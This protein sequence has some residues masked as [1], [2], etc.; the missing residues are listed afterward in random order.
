MHFPNRFNSSDSFYTSYAPPHYYLRVVLSLSVGF[1]KHISLSVYASYCFICISSFLFLW[2]GFVC[3][4]RKTGRV[5]IVIQKPIKVV[6][7]NSDENWVKT[8]DDE[9]E[10]REKKPPENRSKFWFSLYP[11]T[12][13]SECTV[14]TAKAVKKIT[15]TSASQKIWIF[16]D[17]VAFSLRWSTFMLH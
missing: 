9:K 2:L 10:M 8:E 16:L 11:Q 5:F 3:H 6:F 1:N 4:C 7:K 13:T 14:M 17:F 12:T 15:T